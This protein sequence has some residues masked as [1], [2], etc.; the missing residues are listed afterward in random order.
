MTIA[1]ASERQFR[2]AL[3]GWT[4]TTVLLMKLHGDYGFQYSG[5][6]RVVI[7]H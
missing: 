1:L 6:G 3:S 7:V 5:I 2:F 4:A